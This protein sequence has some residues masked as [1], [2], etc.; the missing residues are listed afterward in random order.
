VPVVS[1][2]SLRLT[3]VLGAGLGV[4]DATRKK[5]DPGHGSVAEP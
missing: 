2:V 4:G 3:V 1:P 5:A